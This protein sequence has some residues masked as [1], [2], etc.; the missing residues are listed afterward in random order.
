MLTR[1]QLLAPSKRPAEAFKFRDSEIF[2]RGMTAGELISFQ[3]SIQSKKNGTIDVDQD[4]FGA[5]LLVRC[6]V[7]KTGTRLLQDDDWALLNK[8]WDAEEFQP[9]LTIAL[10][11]N[12]YGS[13]EGN[14]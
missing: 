9:A 5:K 8:T 11:L 2:L 3:R 12:G 4:S 13:T 7:D 1:E 6:I 14:A 10:R